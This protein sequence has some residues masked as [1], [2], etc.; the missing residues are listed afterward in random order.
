[1][2]GQKKVTVPAAGSREPFLLQFHV[3]RHKEM[4]WNLDG[5]WMWPDHGSRMRHHKVPWCS[6]RVDRILHLLWLSPVLLPNH[7][8]WLWA[9]VPRACPK[10]SSSFW[11]ARFD[12]RAQAVLLQW[13]FGFLRESCI[14]AWLIAHETIC[15]SIHHT[16]VY[17]EHFLATHSIPSFSW[18]KYNLVLQLPSG[19]L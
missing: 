4:E 16:T 7:L 9:L 11:E 13:L 3:L 1:M 5:I 2:N 12:F 19:D 6:C 15:L 14:A 10:G 18:Y 17:T 8:M